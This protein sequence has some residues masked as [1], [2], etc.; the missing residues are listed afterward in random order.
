MGFTVALIDTVPM[1][2]HMWSVRGS[3]LFFTSIINLT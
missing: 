1:M 3:G 2:V